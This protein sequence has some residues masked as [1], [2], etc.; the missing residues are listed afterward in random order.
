MHSSNSI[1]FKSIYLLI[2]IVGFAQLKFRVKSRWNNLVPVR[3]GHSVEEKFV[4]DC[5]IMPLFLVPIKVDT[6]FYIF[7]RRY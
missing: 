3:P 6:G 1:L 5:L 4:L 7:H 2:L